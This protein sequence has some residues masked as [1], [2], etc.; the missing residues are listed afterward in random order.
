LDLAS[1]SNGNYNND[2]NVNDNETL[3]RKMA[4]IIEIIKSMV[5]Y[6][7]VNFILLSSIQNDLRSGLKKNYNKRDKFYELFL[8]YNNIKYHKI[9]EN[10]D[11]NGEL[12][13]NF[14]ILEL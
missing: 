2:E 1:H 11:I 7:R 3:F 10:I 14:F 8:V 6:H 9:K 12:I 5:N 13:S 4:T